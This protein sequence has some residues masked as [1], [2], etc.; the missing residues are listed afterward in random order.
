MFVF[1]YRFITGFLKISVTGEFTERLLNLFAV[2]NITIWKIIKKEN[3]MTFYIKIKDFK[4]LR[5]IKN[6]TKIRV[7]I[8]K[9]IGLPF[10]LNRYKMRYG[11]AVG[12]AVFLI[13][14]N[15]LGL[16]VW[17]V[18][19]VGNVPDK[20]VVLKDCAELDI[21][22]GNLVKNLDLPILKEKLL[23]KNS[24]LAW[25]SINAEGSRIT[26]N[27]SEIKNKR[28]E[29]T[30]SNIVAESD[31]II[32]KI[33]ITAG[34]AEVLLGQPVIKGQILISGTVDGFGST[35]FVK[36]EGEI[37]AEITEKFSY[38][39]NYTQIIK[40]YD[41]GKNKY[42][43]DFFT[44]KIPLYLGQNHGYYD[45]EYSEN[46]LVIFGKDMPIRLHKRRF[47]YYTDE[48]FIFTREALIIKTH[49][50]FDSEIKNRN[51][52]E[53][54]TVS[55]VITDSENGI[56]ANYTIRYLKSIGV[57]EKLLF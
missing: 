56:T 48:E 44:L 10:Y 31:G 18:E 25:G 46:P 2:N 14:L 45:T 40:N 8:I 4:R 57:S 1:V 49:E 35:T 6:Q 19:I 54:E 55:T 30:P 20:N 16:F 9:R 5:K 42:V 43:L 15:V 17:D 39:Q 36:A 23:L 22:Y 13:I 29:K 26:V 28:E 38:E 51:I 11:I 34:Q 12:L 32:K 33:S 37:L 47:N 52:S 24:S 53:F 21:R 27:V 7:K 50:L 41:Y 3:K